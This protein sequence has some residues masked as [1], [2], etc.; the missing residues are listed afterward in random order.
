MNIL[1]SIVAFLG[2]VLIIAVIPKVSS[3][4]PPSKLL[5]GC[6]AITDLRVGLVVQPLYVNVLLSAEHSK[7]CYYSLSLF[8][9]KSPF[10]CGVSLMTLTAISVDRLLALKLGTRYRQVV[11]LR[12]VCVLTVIIWLSNTAKAVIV[13]YIPLYGSGI[14][15]IEVI[16]CII[17]SSSCY[18]KIYRILRHHQAQVQQHVHQGQQNGGETPVNIAR[19]RKTVSSALW[20]QMTLLTCYLPF[21]VAMAILVI[22]KPLVFALHPLHGDCL[23]CRLFFLLRF[24]LL[25]IK[26]G[27]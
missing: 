18:T 8:N 9:T 19:Y 13:L 7:H 21:V 17:A 16:L 20:V 22:Y 24:F 26:G 10:F 2:N 25:K 23:P 11:S 14:F 4:H 3:L 1:L 15:A 6:L 27:P 12:R 5:L